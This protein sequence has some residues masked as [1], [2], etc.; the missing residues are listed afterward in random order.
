[1]KQELTLEKLLRLCTEAA[2]QSAGFNEHYDFAGE[3]GPEPVLKL[4]LQNEEMLAFVQAVYDAP[5]MRK[6]NPL[7]LMAIGILERHR[8][9]WP[10]PTV[11]PVQF[12]R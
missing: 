6:D 4:L 8:A 11:D 12:P 1:M 3:V 5:G 7:K 9:A 10:K 2:S